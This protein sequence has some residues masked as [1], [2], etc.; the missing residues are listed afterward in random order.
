MSF[1]LNKNLIMRILAYTLSLLFLMSL[2]T[3]C[4]LGSDDKYETKTA[5]EEGYTYSYVSGDDSKTRHYVLDNGLNVYLSVY[6]GAPRIDTKIPVKAGG[7]NDPET[8]TGLAHYLEHMMFKGNSQFGT[9]DWESEK[10]LLDSIENLYQHYRTVEDPAT[11]KAI[12]RQ[13]DQVSN[14]AS[15]Y[16]IAN[17]Y[18]KML[19]FIGAKG[20][21][22]YTTEDRTVYV[23]DIPSNQLQNWLK[24]ESTRFKEI[25][26]RLFHTE[27]EAVYEEKNRSLDNDSWKSYETLYREIFPKHKYGTQTV[28]GTID[29]LKNPSITDINAYFYKY[30]IPNNFAICLSGDLNP[31]EAI[32]MIDATFGKLP[33]K[34]LTVD[35]QEEEAPITQVKEATVIGPES[36]FVMLGFRFGG[37]SAPEQPILKMIDYIL[38]NSSAG[39]IDLNLVQ[40]QKILIGSCFINDFNDYSIHQLYGE[41]RDGQSLEELKDLL[42]S[43]IDLIKSGEFEDWLPDAVVNDLKMSYMRQMESNSARTNAMVMAF[44][45]DMQWADYISNLDKMTKITKEEIVAFANE[46]YKDN[47]YVVVYKR[48]GEDP[49]KQKVDKPEINKVDLD[50]ESQSD[51]LKTIQSNKVVEITPKFLDYSKDITNGLA[52]GG[53]PILHLNNQE[54]QLFTMHYLVDFGTNEDPRIKM[55]V[56]YLK[57][58]GTG[59]L[60]AS[61]FKKELYKLD[62]SFSVFS[63]TDR[64]YV[65]LRGLHE[66]M[67]PAMKLFEELLNKPNGDNQA[68][69]NLISDQHK[70]RADAKLQKGSILWS[71]LMNYVRYGPESPFT[72]VLSNDQLNKMSSD[73]LLSVIK[74]IATTKHRVLYYGPADLNTLT[75]YLN[76]HHQIPE[77]LK[78]AP[79]RKEFA[80]LNSDDTQVF[81]TDYD[82]VQAEI[83]FNH[84]G[85]IYDKS[86]TPEVTLFNQY[87]GGD[88]SS[89]VFQEIRE[90]QGLAYSVYSG[91][92]QGR[93]SEKKDAMMSYVGTQ[94]DKQ[95][96]AMDAMMTLL[97]NLPESEKSFETSKKSILSKIESERII[98]SDIL[99]NYLDAA[100]QGLDYDVRKDIYQKVQTMTYSDLK[101]FHG[102]YIKD[103]KHNIA[104][105]GD[106]GKINFKAL[107]KYGKVVKLTLEDLFGYEN[108][109]P[110]ILN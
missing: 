10:V 102:K 48:K 29:H 88:M 57:Y 68:L 19:S 76:E 108:V 43:Q 78:P 61:D 9:K 50:R 22:A 86:I 28:I 79:K 42:L 104:V 35:I 18:D 97:N 70:S 66:N 14:E 90:A 67:I 56:E 46:H 105:I 6:E 45:N 37:T 81:F 58:L 31:I 52:K 13:I 84:N 26:N 33:M 71:G 25:T 69:V 100:E 103:K 5:T 32:K 93:S 59:D 73:E 41:P 62:C 98:K 77:T 16:A 20:T 82:M 80:E 99:F 109:S 24:I 107:N 91:Y 94:A 2:S 101:S 72:N 85:D 95:E 1:Q 75:N 60:S 34:E 49:N 64:T 39:L 12:Y 54:N 87:F 89:V 65:T 15:K 36:E 7:K 83:I 51:F 53:I 110:D 27:L 92:D 96:E 23:N 30:Y 44:S 17:E 47:N 74:N 40:S 106:E 38:A 4:K 63:S 55:A 11:R 8:S 21:N 3:S